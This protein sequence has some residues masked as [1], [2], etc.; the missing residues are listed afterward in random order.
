M[1]S[2]SPGC[3]NYARDLKPVALGVRKGNRP[4]DCDPNTRK[5]GKIK[6]KKEGRI[7]GKEGIWEEL[8]RK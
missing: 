2:A 1:P 5:A 7:E 4:S 6:I 3:P 8:S